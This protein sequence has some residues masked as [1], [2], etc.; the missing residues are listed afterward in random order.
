MWVYNN[1]TDELYH[2]GVPG[3]RWGVRR[4]QNPDGSLTARGRRRLKTLQKKDDKWM[5]KN[6]RKIIKKATKKSS[7][8]LKKYQKELLK[9]PDAFNASGKLRATTINNYNRKMAAL[10]SEQVSNLKAPSGRV[11][12]FIAKR[13]EIGVHLAISSSG[14]NPDEFKN[15]VYSSGKVAYKKDVIDRID[16]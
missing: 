11:V 4:Y 3:M 15:G 12:H 10:M 9:D 13:G 2:D 5:R 8:E 6:S 16:V 14:Y 7:K 1:N